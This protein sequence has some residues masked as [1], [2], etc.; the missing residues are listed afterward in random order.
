MIAICVDAKDY[1]EEINPAFGTCSWK[2]LLGR[3]EDNASMTLGLATFHAHGTLHLHHHDDGEFYYCVGGSGW[4]TID[5]QIIEIRQHMAIMIP[6]GCTHGVQAGA[7]GL[8]FLY[9]FANQP[10]FSSVH[11]QFLPQV[12]EV[13]TNMP[14][15]LEEAQ[16]E[17]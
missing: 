5:E 6:G 10:K 13:P 15:V 1:A 12:G 4:V 3:D 8:Q 7:D 17:R 2:T 16:I 11:Y 14:N 9:G